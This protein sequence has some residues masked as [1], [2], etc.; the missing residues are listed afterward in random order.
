MQKTKTICLQER[1]ITVRE[2][3][4]REVYDLLSK[5]QENGPEF[6]DGLSSVFKGSTGLDLEDLLDFHASEALALWDAVLEVNA[7]FLSLAERVG[8]D[9]PVKAILAGIKLDWNARSAAS[10][11]G[12]TDQESGN[13]ASPSS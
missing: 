6:M 13:T 10:S 9:Q 7:S 2:L 4:I 3:R 1:D 5:A 11:A 8:L 12:A